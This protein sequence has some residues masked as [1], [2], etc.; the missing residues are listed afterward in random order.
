[1]KKFKFTIIAAVLYISFL[2]AELYGM[3]CHWTVNEWVGWNLS[4]LTAAGWL[5]AMVL[6]FW[7]L[8]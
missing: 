2:E 1:M 3:M 4:A 6:S 5:P 8:D 7:E